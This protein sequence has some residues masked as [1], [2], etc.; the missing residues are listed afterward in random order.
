M[1]S[2]GG[3]GLG[4]WGGCPSNQGSTFTFIYTHTHTPPPTPGLVSEFERLCREKVSEEE[5][6]RDQFRAS[7]AQLEQEASELTARLG[8]RGSERLR[9]GVVYSGWYVRGLTDRHRGGC[10]EPSHP[11]H[12]THTYHALPQPTGLG[13]LRLQLWGPC[14]VLRRGGHAHGPAGGPGG[15][16]FFGG[17]GLCVR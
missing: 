6:V 14:L 7:I 3:L 5:S 9:F 17:E 10:S 8:V 13:G 15:A 16:C 4:V 12:S 1:R 11:I 2:F